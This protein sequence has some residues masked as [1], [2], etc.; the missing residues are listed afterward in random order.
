M[1]SS[2]FVNVLLECCKVAVVYLNAPLQTN[3]TLLKLSDFLLGLV[4]GVDAYNK[5]LR[6]FLAQEHRRTLTAGLQFHHIVSAPTKEGK[7]LPGSLL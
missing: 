3:Q 5:D 2:S 6:K 1:T 7:I 4:L